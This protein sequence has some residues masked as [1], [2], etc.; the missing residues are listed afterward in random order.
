MPAGALRTASRGAT[1]SAEGLN[2]RGPQAAS[3]GRGLQR[4]GGQRL[5]DTVV[6]MAAPRLEGPPLAAAAARAW[7]SGPR[8]I[9][10]GRGGSARLP[11]TDPSAAAPAVPAPLPSGLSE[12]GAAREASLVLRP[13][14]WQPFRDASLGGGG[15]GR[16]RRG[17]G[18]GRD[19]LTRRR[20]RAA[21]GTPPSLVQCGG[22][23]GCGEGGG[24]AHGAGTEA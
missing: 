1:G 23:G 22:S 24:G 11:R 18:R 14:S 16:A 6:T 19:S 5:G 3:V 17:A 15:R 8:R 21:A 9:P 4:V 10:E 12:S 2:E 7:P 20:G 13:A